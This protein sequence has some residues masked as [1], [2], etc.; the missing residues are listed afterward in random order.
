LSK[1]L[2]GGFRPGGRCGGPGGMWKMR[3]KEKFQNMTP[4]ERE[5]VRAAWKSR[6]GRGG[7]WHMDEDEKG[8]EIV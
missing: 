1:I 2:F 4:E 5:K 8:N 6:C 3:M 7:R